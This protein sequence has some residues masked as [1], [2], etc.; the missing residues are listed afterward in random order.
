MDDSPDKPQSK[1]LP[2]FFWDNDCF[3]SAGYLSPVEN[4]Q[5]NPPQ[6][7]S[8]PLPPKSAEKDFSPMYKGSA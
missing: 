2:D 1:P 3:Q 8:T 6:K 5:Q 7:P 4:Y